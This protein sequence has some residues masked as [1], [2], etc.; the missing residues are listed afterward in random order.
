MSQVEVHFGTCIDWLFLIENTSIAVMDKFNYLNLLLKVLAARI[1]PGLTLNEGNYS[2]AIKLLQDRFG[3]PQQIISVHMEEL[4]KISHCFGE[5][6]SSLQYV[7]DKI[8]V[9][10]SAI[11]LSSAQY[12]S[13][14]IPIIMTKLTLGLCLCI[15]KEIKNGSVGNGLRRER[16]L[17]W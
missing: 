8:N 17:G 14:L 2:S 9:G 11:G 4:L 16:L 12:G 3:R 15:A 10:L 5:K 13:L 6:A 1:I 7:Y